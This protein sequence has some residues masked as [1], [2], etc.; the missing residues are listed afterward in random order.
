VFGQRVA[1]C[2]TKYDGSPHWEFDS[3]SVVEEG[4][5]LIT[6]NFAGQVLKNANGPWTTPYHVRNHFWLDGRYL[7]LPMA[8]LALLAGVGVARAV[9]LL[10]ARLASARPVAA[11]ALL[12]GVAVWFGVLNAGYQ[13]FLT[14]KGDDT[15]AFLSSLSATYPTLPEASRLIVTEY[16][17]SLSLFPDDGY[18]LRPAVRLTYEQDVEVITQSQIDAGAVPP[19]RAGDLWYPPR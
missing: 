1:V 4:P 12:A 8:G 6:Q 19:P 17:P 14:A 2:S 3:W 15:E 9:E 10:P 13:G 7:Y 16:P 11:A 18:M 5:L